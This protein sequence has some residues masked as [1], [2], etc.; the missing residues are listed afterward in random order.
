MPKIDHFN[1][2]D[3]AR[4]RYAAGI[5][6]SVDGA[7]DTCSVTVSGLGTLAN[8]PL[9]YHC[10]SSIVEVASNG[11]LVGAAG[12]FQIGDP[13]IVQIHNG[14]HRVVGHSDGVKRKCGWK[15]RLFYENALGE[16]VL[17]DGSN[18]EWFM[19]FYLQDADG[20]YLAYRSVYNSG[21]YAPD[22]NEDSFRLRSGS[23]TFD[24]NTNT[25][26]VA[27]PANLN[28]V[29]DN[30]KPTTIKGL[31]WVDATV[32]FT[33]SDLIPERNQ[34]GQPQSQYPNRYRENVLW[35]NWTFADDIRQEGDKISIS[36][37]DIVFNY[38][39]P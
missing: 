39:P 3:I 2:G 33:S 1:C 15:I 34:E 17:I 13:V 36:T 19:Q 26:S 35:T 30:E 4:T 16:N 6:V 22:G 27:P 29:I 23:S 20:L 28:E 12:A 24:F 21:I 7:I 18:G 8:V 14:V 10:S 5:I 9:Y 32:P 25:F 11:S 31:Y 37:I 38:E